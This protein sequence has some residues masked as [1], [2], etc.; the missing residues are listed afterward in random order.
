MFVSVVQSRF[1]SD[2][3]GSSPVAVVPY[4]SRT[5]QTVRKSTE[6]EAVPRELEAP[7]TPSRIPLPG[8][9]FSSPSRLLSSAV[10]RVRPEM[11]VVVANVNRTA[12]QFEQKTD[13]AL[14]VTRKVS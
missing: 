7:D 6:A 4:R 12:E 11:D 14:T 1:D 8:S 10:A 9:A 3:E 13:K 2:N 5:K